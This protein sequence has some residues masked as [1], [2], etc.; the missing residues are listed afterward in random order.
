MSK[1]S[2]YCTVTNV[3][4]KHNG[5]KIKREL[6][7]IPGVMSSRGFNIGRSLDVGGTFMSEK[8]VRLEAAKKISG[9]E[10]LKN[11]NPNQHH[12]IKK[13]ALGPNTKR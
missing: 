3:E 10:L 6:G 9:Q 2:F 13:Q 4:G 11:E 12:N 8:E 7:I 5:Q 1:A